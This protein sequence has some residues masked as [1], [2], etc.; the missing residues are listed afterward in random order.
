M[1][2]NILLAPENNIETL[3]LGTR[4]S[5]EGICLPYKLNLGNYIQAIESGANVLLMF[6]APGT[7]RLGNYTNM[8]EAKLR[9]LGYD[10]EMVVF[11][12]YKGK[13]VEIARK[14]SMA[15]GNSNFLKTLSGIKL[16]F[17][18]FDALDKIEKDYF[19][20]DLEKFTQAKPNLYIIGSCF[21]R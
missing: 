5:V 12:M 8:A 14:F 19:I 13:L 20:L 21:N 11:D 3:N 1:G 15:T 10:F 6:N 17:T 2:A 4:H 9:E 16:G 7:C 18:K